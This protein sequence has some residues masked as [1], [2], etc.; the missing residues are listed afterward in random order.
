MLGPLEVWDQGR[1]LTIGGPQQR[2]VLAILCLVWL[3]PAAAALDPGTYLPGQLVV[4]LKP[5]PAG[6]AAHQANRE[7]ENE[8][9]EVERLIPAVM[10]DHV[11]FA[12]PLTIGMERCERWGEPFAFDAGPDIQSARALAAPPPP[13]TTG[14]RGSCTPSNI[15]TGTRARN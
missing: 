2:A 11:S 13:S 15:T 5:A 9:D 4:K 7:S 10:E 14:R 1:Q 6:F 12:C 8:I 3:Q